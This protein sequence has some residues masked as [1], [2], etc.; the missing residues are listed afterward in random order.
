MNT[1]GESAA[2]ESGRKRWLA[3][4]VLA[5]SLGLIVLDGTIVGVA[6]PVIIADLKMSL[7][8]AEWVNSLYSV[9]FAAL[10]M[11]A[12]R[13]GDRF[14][15]RKMLMI[16]M[17]IFVVGSLL[18]AI[19]S[20][21]SPLIAARA[22]QGL[23]GAMILPSTLS[24]VNATFRGKDR[25]IAFGIW[26]AVMAG[27]AA[28][29]PLFGGLLTTYAT[30]HWIFL[31]NI[32]LGVVLIIA[33][34]AIVP[35]TTGTPGGRDMIGPVLAA[36][37]FG[38]F[39]FGLIEGANLGW[40]KPEGVLAIGS[41]E[42]GLDA[43]VSPAPV[44][45]ALGV[46]F[47]AAFIAYEHHRTK[48]ARTGVLDTALFSIPTFAWGNLTAGLVAVGEFSL[49]FVLPLY[50]VIVLGLDTLGAG[51][52]LVAMAVGAFIAGGSA[53]HLSAALG[54][55]R[56]VVLG[57]ALEVIGT[58]GTALLLGAQLGSGWVAATMTVYGVG[59]GL[60]SAQV[61]SVVLGEVP[62]AESGTGS[63]VQSTVRQIGAALGA[64]LGG[65][66]LSTVLGTH[67]VQQVAPDEFAHASSIAVWSSVVVLGVALLVSLRLKAVAPKMSGH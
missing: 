23:G 25:A 9:V 66:V 22:V 16:G 63:A 49:I 11:T 48:N 51:L 67:V 56:V 38:S 12:G 7:T 28:L 8:G 41:W 65:T 31:I 6:L 17:G 19:S 64:A 47:I 29:G 35:E 3:L 37:G 55:A 27:A 33:A 52:V 1:Q 60:A 50:L 53:R 39:V 13:L 2:P 36:I 20:G 30:W 34:L 61:T 44:A 32:P 21:T 4:V 46:I 15:R 26:G 62:V 24:T 42:W 59:V 58:A 57:L 40:W 14:G 18:A 43:P 54:P 45:L 5:V 10:L